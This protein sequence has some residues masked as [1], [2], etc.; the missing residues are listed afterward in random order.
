MTSVDISKAASLADAYLTKFN[1][2]AEICDYHARKQAARSLKL[3][4]DNSLETLAKSIAQ[5][6]RSGDTE[7][8]IEAMRDDRYGTLLNVQWLV[9]GLL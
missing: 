8:F 9:E 5:K 6:K 1:T 3:E 4:I 7:G 2:I